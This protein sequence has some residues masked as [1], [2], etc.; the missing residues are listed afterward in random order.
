MCCCSLAFPHSVSCVS[1]FSRSV[2][3]HEKYLKTTI[4]G[5]TGSHPDYAVV[6]VNSLAGVTKMTKEHL[7]HRTDTSRWHVD[8]QSSAELTC[9]RDCVKSTGVVL[10]LEIP[11]ICVV[12]KVDM[13]PSTVLE[14]TKKQLFRILK[15]SAAN[16]LPI[17]MRNEKDIDT[18][19]TNSASS[20]KICPVFFISAVNGTHVDLLTSYLSR[21]RPHLEWLNHYA[22]HMTTP[23][24]DGSITSHPNACE[25]SI[26][27][28]FNVSGVGIVVSGTLNSG[29]LHA[30]STMLLGPQSDNTFVQVLVRS[31]H[32]KRVSC[33]SVDAGQSCAVSIRAVK[34]KETLKRTLI[35]RGMVLVDPVVN[36]QSTRVF[37]AEVLIL[38]HPTTIKLG[39]QAVLHCG[40]IRQ[41]AQICRIK[42]QCLRTGDKSTCR[43]RFLQR[44]EFLHTG[45]S[46]V[47]REGST[48]GIGKITRIAFT[49]EEK[50]EL[51]EEERARKKQGGKSQQHPKKTEG[52]EA[53]EEEHEDV[54]ASA[55]TVTASSSFSTKAPKDGE[56]ASTKQKWSQKEKVSPHGQDAK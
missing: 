1:L 55:P 14:A 32:Y 37:D 21:L 40:M 26:D 43:F 33:A 42:Q 15:S 46:F 39:Y 19:I 34:R 6:I 20:T 27:E 29:T 7:G 23:N 8:H 56:D 5:L 41:T 16:K 11:L 45:A 35:R 52:A 31:L 24:A 53:Q 4:A 36:P 13:A 3:G 28:V 2:A 25:F 50:E 48:K 38:H 9:M 12:S 18:V 49:S 30:N 10:A 47:F 54:P 17:Q 22:H 44:E 51:E